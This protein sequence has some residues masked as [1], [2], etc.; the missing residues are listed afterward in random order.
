MD[1]ISQITIA[2]VRSIERLQLDLGP[3]NVLIGENGGGKSTI[4][5]CLELLSKAAKPDFMDQFYTVHQGMAGLLRKGQTTLS[6]GLVIEDNSGKDPLVSY[7]FSLQ[8][9]GPGAIIYKEQVLVFEKKGQLPLIALERGVTEGKFFDQNIKKLSPLP[10][11]FSDRLA[12]G[13]FGPLPAQKAIVRLLAILE[14]I[15]VHLHIDTTAGWAARSCQ[16]VQSIRGPTPFRKANRLNLLGFNLTNAWAA[17]KNQTTAEWEYTL[18]LLRLGLGERVDT[19][20]VEPDSGG[21]IYLKLKFKDLSESIL[22][23]SLSDG[24]LIWLAMIAMVRINPNRSLFAIDEP[25]LHLH[26]YLLGR[27]ISL[28]TSMENPA[29]VLLST[30][31]DRV[32]ELI[33]NP[34]DAIVVCSLNGNKTELLQLNKEELSKWLEKFGSVGQLRAEG[35]LSQVLVAAPGSAQEPE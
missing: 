10:A 2:N 31:S 1:R 29:P 15:E 32:L 34:A 5:E 12:I 17:L 22:A 18:S 23:S 14:K 27:V 16:L 35:Y 19:V 6:L 21:S 7:M 33:E 13:N 26:P 28:L 8:A 30:H 3:V 24:Q 25:E 11:F 4:L 20:Q 9:Q